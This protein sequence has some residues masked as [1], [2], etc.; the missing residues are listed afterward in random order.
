MKALLE[1]K[2][3]QAVWLAFLDEHGHDILKTSAGVHTLHGAMEVLKVSECDYYNTVK[4]K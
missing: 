2:G 4:L 3:G 1:G